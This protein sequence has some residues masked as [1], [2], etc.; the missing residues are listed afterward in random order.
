MYLQSA[1]RWRAGGTPSLVRVSTV[2]GDTLRS[3]PTLSAAL[4]LAPSGPGAIA[5]AP[6]DLRTRADALYREMRE[7]L[8][9]GDWGA[10]GRAFD[11]LGATLR[12]PSR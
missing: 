3:G 8:R 11:A 12:V 1:Y 4:G 6:A 2:V 10:F 7:A 9:N 5:A